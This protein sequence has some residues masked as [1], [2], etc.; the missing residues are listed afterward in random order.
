MSSAV[1]S[2]LSTDSIRR[3]TRS[4]YWRDETIYAIVRNHA[5]RSPGNTAVRDRFQHM[6][7]GDLIATAD[8]LAD[9]L[10]R[11]GLRAGQRLLLWLPTRIES[12]LALLACSRNGYVWCPSPHRN[13]TVAEVV[14][15]I[16][17]TRAAAL[18]YQPGYNAD[19]DRQS[20]ESEITTLPSLRRVLRLDPPDAKPILDMLTDTGRDDE[21]TD[22]VAPNGD[23]NCISYL[24]FT[25]GSTGA[26]KG[27]MHS[28]NTLLATARAIVVDWRI[29]ATNVLNQV[30]YSRVN[31]L[32]GSPQFGLP[33]EA[34]QMRRVQTSLRLR[35]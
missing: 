1:L 29:D 22:G 17:R 35:F 28:D 25:S 14:D 18:I 23:P 13:H 21:S 30:T 2:L 3:H 26:P 11:H 12:V 31:S 9:D 5:L 4:G 34:N 27:V 19:V 15:L 8:R 10:V 32:V 20:I 6:T 33:S 24:A 7:Y 16:E